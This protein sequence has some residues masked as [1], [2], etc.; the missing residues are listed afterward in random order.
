[1]SNVVSE[2]FTVQATG[3]TATGHAAVF[4]QD[5]NIQCLHLHDSAQPVSIHLREPLPLSHWGLDLPGVHRHNSITL[6]VLNTVF[7]YT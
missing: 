6:Y 7:S 1:M 2:K 5:L 3:F 4:S